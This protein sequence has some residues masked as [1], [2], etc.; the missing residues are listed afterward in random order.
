M[1]RKN[2]SIKSEEINMSRKELLERKE[3]AVKNFSVYIDKWLIE[4]DL[5]LTQQ[6]IE[7]YFALKHPNNR[8]SSDSIKKIQ[9][10]IKSNR[11]A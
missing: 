11:L 2:K 10:T 1:N 5:E 7:R 6:N 3:R 4:N 9:M 8:I